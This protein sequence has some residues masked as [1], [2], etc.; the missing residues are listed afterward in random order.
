MGVVDGSSRS[1]QCQLSSECVSERI[2][3]TCQ[4]LLN[5]YED[6]KFGR[7]TFYGS[8]G[9]VY[10]WCSIS[11]DCQSRDVEFI[12][13]IWDGPHL[14]WSSCNVV[15]KRSPTN[16]STKMTWLWQS[17]RS[18]VDSGNGQISPSTL[19][20]PRMWPASSFIWKRK[21]TVTDF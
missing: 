12:V 3:K 13:T 15:G 9:T 10:W 5:L 6:M 21:Q 20:H 14:V 18:F 16:L 8:L 4:Y 11:A 7:P 2:L 17:S 19:S 1:C